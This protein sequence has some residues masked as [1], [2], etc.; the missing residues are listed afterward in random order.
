MMGV[1]FSRCP[2]VVHA[3]YV[4]GVYTRMSEILFTFPKVTRVKRAQPVDAMD[5]LFRTGYW[6]QR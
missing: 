2:R 3:V 1:F 5:L 4:Y 6:S